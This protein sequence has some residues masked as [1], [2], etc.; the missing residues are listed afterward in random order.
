MLLK[1]LFKQIFVSKELKRYIFVAA[2]PALLFYSFSLAG[3]MF[4][5]FGIMEILRDPAQLSGQ[6]SFLGFLSN[7]GIWLW[8]SSAAICFF[9]ALNIDSADNDKRKELLFLAGM[10]SLMLAVDDFF[11]I[12]DRYVSQKICYLT[13]AVCAVTLLIRHYKTII[14]ID[15]VAFLLAGLLLALS[16]LTDLSGNHI[17]LKYRYVQV[18]EEGF[19][20]IGVTSWLYFNCRVASFRPEHSAASELNINFNR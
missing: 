14:E 4:K 20:F 2:I 13:Y 1:Q 10:L 3:L 9:T 16:I 17:P 12:H 19:K 8:I 6:S 15:G 5:G 11:M 7:I 18:F